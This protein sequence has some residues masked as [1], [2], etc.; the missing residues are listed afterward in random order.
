M[1]YV[2]LLT[3]PLCLV[4][5]LAAMAG[6]SKGPNLPT[7]PASGTV[8]LDGKPLEGATVAFAPTNPD[9]KTANG[10]TDPQG[11]FSLQT[12][13]GGTTG[14]AAGAMMGDYVVMVTKYDQVSGNFDAAAQEKVM[15]EMQKSGRQPG[16]ATPGQAKLVTPAK[17][18]NP[19]DSD[20]KATVKASDNQFTF[21]LKSP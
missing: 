15:Q 20:L 3:R 10:T 8:T 16:G 9:G 4:F 2:R 7:V 19:K 12:Y 17:Y 1:C 5:V 21:D 6:C 13:L 18:A 14:Q 11:K